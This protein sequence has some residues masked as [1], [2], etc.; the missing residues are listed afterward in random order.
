MRV[1][2]TLGSRIV[3]RM[4][5]SPTVPWCAARGAMQETIRRLA[6]ERR[7]SGTL[8]PPYAITGAGRRPKWAELEKVL[9]AE[10]KAMRCGEV[11]R[12]APWV[13]RKM[14]HCA[15][16]LICCGAF[17]VARDAHA[18]VSRARGRRI[19]IRWVCVKSKRIFSE[20]HPD[21]EP[22]QFKASRKWRR[23]FAKRHNIT[24][25]KKTNQK[26]KS[27]AERLPEV[28]ALASL[29]RPEALRPETRLARISTG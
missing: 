5:R 22:G 1:F 8:R 3:S 23:R 24:R 14:P 29:S 20:L 6:S 17:V 28:R 12:G 9:S 19:T 18:I 25:R 11:P 4:L 15:P 2:P 13:G 26:K 27:V 21:A 16:V 10:F 7:L